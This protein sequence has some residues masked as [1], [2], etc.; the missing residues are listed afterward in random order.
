MYYRTRT[1]LAGD[2]DGDKKLIQKI[3]DW[4]RSGELALDFTDAHGLIQSRDTSLNCTIKNSLSARM[5]ASKTFVLIVGEKTDSVMSGSCSYCNDYFANYK[6]CLRGYS[7]SLLSYVQY[8]CEKASRDA[9]DGKMRIVVIYNYMTVR[10][11]KC[12]EPVRYLG[13]HIAA[14]VDQNANGNPI[15]DYQRIKKAIMG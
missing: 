14:I 1:Y 13:T 10:R 9:K 11:E 4:R 12:P 15:Y 6:C 3:Y 7:P 2:W 8:E 5:N